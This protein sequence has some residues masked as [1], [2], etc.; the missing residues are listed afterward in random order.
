[1]GLQRVKIDI[2]KDTTQVSNEEFT[3]MLR[4][5][6]GQIKDIAIRKLYLKK[7]H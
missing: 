2:E 3:K 7:Q 6:I 1:V 4:K 5:L